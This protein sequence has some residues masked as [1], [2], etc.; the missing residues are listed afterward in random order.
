MNEFL[1][2]YRLYVKNI[3]QCTYD[4]VW[5]DEEVHI[6]KKLLDKISKKIDNGV[7][8][9]NTLKRD[10]D[11]Y[12]DPPNFFNTL[13]NI[14]E[15]LF[16]IENTI[17]LKEQGQKQDQLIENKPDQLTEEN[18]EERKEEKKQE[19]KEPKIERTETGEWKGILGDEKPIKKIGTISI[20]QTI[21]DYIWNNLQ[22]D[23]RHG[24]VK[25]LFKKFYEEEIDRKLKDSSYITCASGY[26]RY[27]KDQDPLIISWDER[28]YSK[29]ANKYGEGAKEKPF[30]TWEIQIIKKQAKNSSPSYIQKHS[31]SHRTVQEITIKAK[32]MGLKKRYYQRKGRN[33]KSGK[34]KRWT[35]LEDNI[36]RDHQPT[37]N[38]EKYMHL[39][40]DRTL[41]A[42][43]K[44]ARTLKVYKVTDSTHTRRIMLESKEENKEKPEDAETVIEHE[45]NK[46]ILTEETR[47]ILEEAKASAE[48]KPEDA[49]E[50]EKKIP[51]ED[52]SVKTNTGN[53][54]HKGT[55]EYHLYKIAMESWMGFKKGTPL[56]M[57]MRRMSDF[58]KYQIDNAIDMLVKN[59]KAQRAPNNFIV[60]Y[61]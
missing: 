38:V 25:N 59:R 55:A 9:I 20:Y 56:I 14:K 27:F 36:I 11:E 41:Y 3:D 58:P 24:D 37:V 22:N 61:A 7:I 30:E 35:E 17:Y 33:K 21:K 54:F 43:E 4:E 29:D 12:S 47:K 23:F 50:S 18:V 1:D 42:I 8:I 53:P 5:P 60:F 57:V 2:I 45:L 6:L 26:I 32:E 52:T 39:L 46:P 15:T 51:T 49:D 34:I 19:K 40:P 31:L 13:I 44:R 16:E 28:D 10:L 48:K